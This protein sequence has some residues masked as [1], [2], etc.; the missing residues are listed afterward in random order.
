MLSSIQKGRGMLAWDAFQRS[1]E[2]DSQGFTC[3]TFF[4]DGV[5]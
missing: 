3:S 1:T 5:Q 2:V 4:G